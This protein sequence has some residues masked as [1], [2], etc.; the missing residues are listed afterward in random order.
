MSVHR[1]IGW[2][3]NQSHPVS[4]IT[5]DGVEVVGSIRQS[6]N[7]SGPYLQMTSSDPAVAEGL[8]CGQ[9]IRV[10]VLKGSEG[11]QVQLES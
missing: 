10:E 5:C 6:V 7:N 9:T 3:E 8:T 2:I 4:I 1:V 11:V